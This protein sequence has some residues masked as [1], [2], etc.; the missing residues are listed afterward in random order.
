L[1]C[2]EDKELQEAAVGEHEDLLGRIRKGLQ[3][4]SRLMPFGATLGMS[5]EMVGNGEAIVSLRADE[6][7]GNILGYTHGGAICTLADTAMGMAHLGTLDHG[8]TATT[9]DIKVNFLR[10]A[11]LHQELRAHAKQ[12]K[13]GRTLS[14][15]EC[16]I[17]DSEN[18]LVA[19]ASGTMMTLVDERTEGR[20]KFHF[21]QE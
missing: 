15:M 19:H 7:H 3:K 12:I 14:L 13:H 4:D 9:V 1:E 17:Y 2:S 8:E 10:P 6:R 11:W 5:I 20:Q 21:E 16:S 18:Q